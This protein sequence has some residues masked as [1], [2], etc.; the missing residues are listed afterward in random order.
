M[1]VLQEE[2]PGKACIHLYIDLVFYSSFK[3]L[4][5]HGASANVSQSYCSSN[6]EA[7]APAME[8]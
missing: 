1:G 7:E 3:R 2:S 8:R 4:L 5:I 6:E